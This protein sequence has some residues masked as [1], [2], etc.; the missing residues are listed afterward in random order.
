MSQVWMITGSSWGVGR[1]LA[2][3]VLAAGHELVATARDPA[4]LADL[5]DRYGEQVRS[6]A[7]D[8]TDPRAAG[9]AIEEAG[10]AFGRLDVLVNNAGYGNIGSIED[11]SLQD[12]RAPI[13]TNLLGG[14]KLTNAA[15]PVP[16]GHP[17]GDSIQLSSNACSPGAP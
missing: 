5:V 3:A 1:A 13:Q 14:L 2:G 6:C 9:N 4:Q 15:I 8:V 10:R 12:L 17:T 11:T 16:P 7:L